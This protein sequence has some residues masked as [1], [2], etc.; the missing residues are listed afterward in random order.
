[1]IIDRLRDIGVPVIGSIPIDHIRASSAVTNPDT[2]GRQFRNMRNR[3]ITKAAALSG[4]KRDRSRRIA[5]WRAIF[6]TGMPAMEMF[7]IRPASTDAIRFKSP[8][9]SCID[10]TPAA[11]V[12]DHGSRVRTMAV[13]RPSCERRVPP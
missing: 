1:M 2:T 11:S 6:R 13:D 5:S 8:T 3:M 4:P 9:R 12:A 7:A 10:L